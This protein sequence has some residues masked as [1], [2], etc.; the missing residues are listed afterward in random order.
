MIP[1]CDLEPGFVKDQLLTFLSVRYMHPKGQVS[2][3]RFKVV[4]VL[5]YRLLEDGPLLKWRH[6]KSSLVV[7]I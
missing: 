3:L 2:Q 4:P 1:F 6:Q 5:L 7:N